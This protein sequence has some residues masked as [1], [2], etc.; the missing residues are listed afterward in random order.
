VWACGGTLSP[1]PTAANG[2]VTAGMLTAVCWIGIVF[3][4]EA[5]KGQDRRDQPRQVGKT[6]CIRVIRSG[7]NA[8]TARG[9]MAAQRSTRRWSHRVLRRREIEPPMIERELRVSG[10]DRP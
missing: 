2:D 4:T 3:R 6:K 9:G 8:V 7:A 5:G 1:G 10:G